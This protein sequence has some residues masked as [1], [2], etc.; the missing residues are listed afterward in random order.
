MKGKQNDWMTR[1]VD[2]LA[3][4]DDLTELH[5]LP[6]LGSEIWQDSRPKGNFLVQVSVG[7]AIPAEFKLWGV[8]V[9]KIGV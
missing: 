2:S 4:F 7:E 9:G 3:Q 5:C 8:D 1:T 6:V